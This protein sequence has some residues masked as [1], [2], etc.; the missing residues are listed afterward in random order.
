MEQKPEIPKWNASLVRDA[1]AA[2]R[3]SELLEQ[4][5]RRYPHLILEEELL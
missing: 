3:L 4:D 5:Y 1:L 2:E